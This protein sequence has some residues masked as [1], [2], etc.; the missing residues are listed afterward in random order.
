MNFDKEFIWM[1]FVVVF[2]CTS[3][4]LHFMGFKFMIAKKYLNYPGLAKWQRRNAILG[5]IF[6]ISVFA[7]YF[8]RNVEELNFAISILSVATFVLMGINNRNFTKKKK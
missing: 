6:G 2:F 5:A 7:R 8:A 3:A 4:V 1:I